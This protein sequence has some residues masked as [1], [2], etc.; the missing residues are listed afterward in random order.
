M[1]T[2]KRTQTEFTLSLAGHHTEAAAGLS[3]AG[4]RLLRLYMPTEM[5][6]E[7][8]SR[9][10]RDCEILLATVK[11]SPE[12]MRK[13][14]EAVAGGRFGTADRLARSLRLSEAEFV[15]E[16]GGL[17]WLVVIGVAAAILLYSGDAN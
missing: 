5:S 3:T 13:L 12:D 8:V 2:P 4:E 14:L 10:T 16:G 17:I 1:Q 7:A 11:K 6:D 15:R 9:L